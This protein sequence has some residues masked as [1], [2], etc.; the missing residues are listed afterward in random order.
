ML[1]IHAYE[2]PIVNVVCPGAGG[3]SGAASARDQ[4]VHLSVFPD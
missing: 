1:Y 2:V 3:D 4:E